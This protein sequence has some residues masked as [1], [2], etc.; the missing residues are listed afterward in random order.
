MARRKKT[1]SRGLGDDP[2]KWIKDETAP[3][4]APEPRAPSPEPQAAPLAPAEAVVE[5]NSPII[6]DAVITIAEAAA[7]KDSLLPHINRKG[8]VCIDGSHVQSVDTAALQVLLA[9]VR[10]SQGHGAVV[11]WTGVSEALLGTAELL[12]V[13]SHIGLR[14]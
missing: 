8:E 2:L 12:G 13:A 4:A 6:L 11:R 9:F 7:L 3:A 5:I 14:A 1:S 10:T